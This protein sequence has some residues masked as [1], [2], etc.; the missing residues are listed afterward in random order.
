MIE[1][2]HSEGCP[3]CVKVRV[4]FEQMGVAYISKAMP[5]RVPSTFKEELLKLGG[6]PQ[7]PFLVDPERSVKMYESDDIIDYVRQNYAK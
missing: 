5:L 7:V 2:Y 4:A 6:K 1:L 3:F